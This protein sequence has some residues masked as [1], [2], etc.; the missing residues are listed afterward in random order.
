[1]IKLKIDNKLKKPR[2]N[3]M[4]DG[5]GQE[6]IKRI[7]LITINYKKYHSNKFPMK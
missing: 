2:V 4:I 1:M 6:R 5:R 7:S 3:I